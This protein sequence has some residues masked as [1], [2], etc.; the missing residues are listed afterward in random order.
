MKTVV[1]Y[2]SGIPN[3]HK[4]KHKV[5]ILKRYIDGVQK[6]GDEDRGGAED[7]LFLCLSLYLFIHLTRGHPI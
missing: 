6:H 4:N 5:D 1:G 7:E 2:A 3:P